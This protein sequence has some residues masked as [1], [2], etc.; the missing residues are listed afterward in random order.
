MEEDD[1]FSRD[2]YP[3]G[4]GGMSQRKMVVHACLQGPGRLMTIGVYFNHLFGL[5]IKARSLFLDLAVL[6]LAIIDQLA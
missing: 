2:I 3:Q 4:S 1:S 6:E 5:F